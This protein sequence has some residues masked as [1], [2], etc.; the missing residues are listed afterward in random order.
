MVFQPKWTGCTNSCQ[1][2]SQPCPQP[3][4]SEGYPGY[5]LNGAQYD[6]YSYR[7]ATGFE[8]RLV[9]SKDGK[10][11]ISDQINN[12]THDG[13]PAAMFKATLDNASTVASLLYERA[14]LNKL[15]DIDTKSGLNMGAITFKNINNLPIGLSADGLSY[16]WREY[17]PE[18]P[19][20]YVIKDED[21]PTNT[22][23]LG[24]ANGEPLDLNHPATKDLFKVNDRVRIMSNGN[25]TGAPE[26]D[27]GAI[28]CCANM[29]VRAVVSV[30]EA[31][32]NGKT[33]PTITLEGWS[34]RGEPE[35]YS[36]KGRNG[37]GA[38][39]NLECLND[40]DKY[41]DG[42]YPGDKVTFEFSSFDPC[43]PMLGGHQVQGWTNKHS[44]IQYMGTELCFDH[45]ELRMGYTPDGIDA[46]LG[47]RFN[48]VSRS[49][50]E[51]QAR[52]FYLGENR[53]I[54]NAAGISGSTMGIL[55]EIYAAHA[56]KPYL[57]LVRSAA[58]TITLEDKARVFL[59][60]L[61]QVQQ[62]K[63]SGNRP[64]ITV[65][66]DDRAISTLYQLNSAF[67]KLGGWVVTMAETPVKNFDILP[68][69][70]TPYG[71]MELLSCPF[72]KEISENSGMLLFLDKK[73]VGARQT[74]EFTVNLPSNNVKR[75]AT[76]G[77]QIKDV[78][79]K[80]VVGG[81][82]CY[83]V[84][85]SFCYIMVG[86]GQPYSPYAILEGFSI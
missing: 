44:Y 55:T 51:Q 40:A 36:Y 84:W 45:A 12:W 29:I 23:M 48:A 42:I 71:D 27:S 68:V 35:L 52:T 62:S 53:Q 75:T 15:Y 59:E 56:A 69:I 34:M 2:N 9:P 57:K 43:N 65:V 67:N 4:W 50:V 72:L 10:Y 83:Y 8:S 5:G 14:D 77:F 79:P 13:K 70:K 73:L 54:Y 61:M 86:I 19:V 17:N 80:K 21:L 16:T 18:R 46:I 63:W 58:H 31:V 47:E 38:N 33:Y 6:G 24:L 66:G 60:V 3:Q 30:G 81:C 32:F 25:L 39:A 11:Y 85:T 41:A 26:C 76:V 74:E 82:A 20:A 22:V 64:T 37:F 49:F 7:T 28:D 78:T 1:I